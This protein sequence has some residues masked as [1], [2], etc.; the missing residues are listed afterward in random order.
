M[1][2]VAPALLSPLPR[3]ALRAALR[4]APRVAVIEESHHEYGFGAEVLA[5]LAESGFSGQV[6]R[7]GMPPVPIAA[8]RSL[9][10]SQLPDEKSI[11]ARILGMF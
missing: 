3:H 5:L 7:I 9:E 6:L 10:A 2:I 11:L 1:R 8:A 4:G